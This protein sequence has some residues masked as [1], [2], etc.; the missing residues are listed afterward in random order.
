MLPPVCGCEAGLVC[1]LA[2][3]ARVRQHDAAAGSAG[4]LRVIAAPVCRLLLTL[5]VVAN[6]ISAHIAGVVSAGETG[7]GDYQ[8]C[9]AGEYAASVTSDHSVYPWW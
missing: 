8:C 5:A 7:R 4:G 6:G 2:V 1:G 3:G 9:C